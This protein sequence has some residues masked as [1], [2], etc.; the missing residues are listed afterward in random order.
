MSEQEVFD[1]I[2]SVITKEYLENSIQ[3][4]RFS[5][6]QQRISLITLTHIARQSV[7]C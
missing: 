6:L 4:K 1:Y 7:P 2:Y 5:E 3:K